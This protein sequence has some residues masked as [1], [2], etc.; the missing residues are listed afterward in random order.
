[1][2]DF[3]SEYIEEPDLVFGRQIEEKDPRIG[4]MYNGPYQYSDESQP[5]PSQIKVGIIG[6]SSTMTSAKR[7][8]EKLGK[9][10][11][12]Q[13]PNKWLY[14]DYPGFIK[15]SIIQCEFITSENWQAIIKENEI[16]AVLS[17]SENINKRIAAGVNLFRDKVKTIGLE[18]NKPDVIICALPPDIEEYCGISEQTR[19]AKKPKFTPIEKLRQDMKS[20]GQTFLDQWGLDISKEHFK[21]DLDLDFRNALKGKVMEFGI[22]VQILKDSVASGFLYYGESGVKETQEP[23]TLAWNLSTALYYKANGKP[24]RLAKLR[25]DTCYVGISFFRNLLNPNVDMQTSMAQV[26]THNGEGIV[27]RGTEVTRDKVA[28]EPHMSQRQARDLLTKALET[29]EQKAGRGPSRIVIHK[30]TSFSYDE[31]AGFSSAADKVSIDFVTISNQHPYRFARTGIYPVIRGT[32]I[33]LAHNKCLLYTSGYIPRIRTYPGQR[34]P[35]P[36]LI[37]HSGDSEMIDIC[38][39]ILG[40][41][42]LN[43]NTT[44]FATYLPITLEFSHKV[45]GILSELEEGKLLQ[46]HYRFYM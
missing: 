34:I 3:K 9:K 29:Y 40:L 38:K 21:E 33:H 23:A 36:L 30:T 44:A 11:E 14:P 43:W 12:S 6:S 1:M 19:G 35:R 37:T 32:I 45:A 10:I 41:T 31:K 17:I 4:L 8:L 16:K 26:F 28:K 13:E 42:K 22:P 46:N 27:I 25:Q 20:V 7:V 2:E 5:S 18:D 15:N 39:E 24:W